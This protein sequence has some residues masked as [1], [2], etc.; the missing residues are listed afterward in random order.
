MADCDV[1]SRTGGNIRRPPAT[2][3]YRGRV[4]VR[5]RELILSAA[6]LAIP[7]TPLRAHEAAEFALPEEFLPAVVPIRNEFAP[8]EI[9]VLP[10]QFRL[11]LTLPENRAIR[12]AVGVG[13]PGLYH[14]GTFVVGRKAKWPS[15]TPTPEMIERDPDAYAPFAEGMPGGPDNPLGARALY[16]HDLSGCDTY[17]RIHGTDKPRTI[18][19]RVS[20]GC[21]RLTNDQIADL[22]ERVPL[23]TRVYLYDQKLS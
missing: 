2:H 9:H 1:L 20:N 3:V 19:T 6:A 17:L 5:R 23:G 15:W 10:D 11:Y 12:Y 7:G 4:F 8:G 14:A 16:L 21:A 13:R 18:G 22:Y